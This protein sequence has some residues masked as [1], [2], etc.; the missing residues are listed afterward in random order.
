[1]P[2]ASLM[3]PYEKRTA[4]RIGYFYAL[5]NE[6]AAMVSVAQKMAEIINTP[7]MVRM[8]KI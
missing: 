5:I 8:P 6:L 1:M 7:S 4:L 2:I 3:M